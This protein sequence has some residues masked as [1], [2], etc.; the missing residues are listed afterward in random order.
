[1]LPATVA[2]ERA[3]TAQ[4]IAVESEGDST[5]HVLEPLAGHVGRGRLEAREPLAQVAGMRRHRRQAGAEPLAERLD[6]RAEIGFA[7]LVELLVGCSS[8]SRKLGVSAAANGWWSVLGP[9]DLAFGNVSNGQ[10][11]T[12]DDTGRQE[13]HYGNT[14]DNHPA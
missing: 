11:R 1:V 12:R 5:A 8:R 2:P 4:S 6:R 14:Y 7:A 13:M 3:P 9:I 10:Y